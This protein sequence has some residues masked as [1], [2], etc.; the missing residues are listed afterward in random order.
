VVRAPAFGDP[1][2]FDTAVALVAQ[3]A[4]ELAAV[5]VEPL[6]QGAAGMQLAGSRGAWPGSA[7]PASSTTSC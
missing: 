4:S 1:A 5:I 3:H 7:P 6:V 2:C